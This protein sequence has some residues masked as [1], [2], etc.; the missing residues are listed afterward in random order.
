LVTIEIYAGESWLNYGKKKILL[1]SPGY[2]KEVVSWMQEIIYAFAKEKYD[3]IVFVCDLG[4]NVEYDK[5]IYKI[6]KDA[7]LN[8]VDCIVLLQSNS[9]EAM[10]VI[11]RFAKKIV[12]IDNEEKC[13]DSH[14]VERINELGVKKTKT[15]AKAVETALYVI[16]QKRVR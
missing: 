14:L 11:E 13:T 5:L 2:N 16:E 10:S 7:A 4:G 8:F 6:W 3:G 12:I 1:F 15:L 9:I